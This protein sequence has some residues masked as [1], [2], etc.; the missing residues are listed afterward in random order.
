VGLAFA[1]LAV[2]ADATFANPPQPVFGRCLAQAGGKYA[3]SGCT[4][5]EAGKNKFE[6]HTE[7]PPN[8]KFRLRLKEG[9]PTLELDDGEKIVCTTVEGTG[10]LRSTRVVQHI[11]LKFKGCHLGQTTVQCTNT[12][13][14]AESG[15][16]VTRSLD[17]VVEV[18]KR[19]IVEG[20]E[21]SAKNKVGEEYHDETGE[22][23]FIG[24]QHFS[25]VNCG[26]FELFEFDKPFLHAITAD[27]MS[28]SLT[29]KFVQKTGEQNP[30]HWWFGAKD[31]LQMVGRG[32][33]NSGGEAGLGSMTLVSE[34]EEPIE[35][36]TVQ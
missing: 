17:G 15:E 4:K 10:E 20:A 21:V 35:I 2:T 12:E 14:A 19:G 27:K 8:H 36:N 7:V 30:D 3:N 6:W 26:N 22:E 28:K 9:T 5:I 16:I 31:S 29:E 32:A 23:R 25:V 13:G 11:T 24:G 18:Y 34:W 1:F 33:G